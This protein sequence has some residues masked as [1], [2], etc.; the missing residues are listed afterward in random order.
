MT[1]NGQASK[2]ENRAPRATRSLGVSVGAFVKDAIFVLGFSI[3]ITPSISIA[4]MLIGFLLVVS[5]LRSRPVRNTRGIGNKLRVLL[6]NYGQGPDQSGRRFLT[7]LGL[8]F[9]GLLGLFRWR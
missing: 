2:Q 9:F 4:A 1:F 7:G 6:S 8:L 3:P 5:G